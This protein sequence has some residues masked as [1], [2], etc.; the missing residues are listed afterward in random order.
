MTQTPKQCPC[1][2][3]KAY[4]HCCEPLHQGAPA[5]DAEQLMRS[6]YSAYALGFESYL[7]ETWH[8]STRPEGLDL[9]GKGAPRWCGLT[10]LRHEPNDDGTAVVEFIAKHEAG[11]LHEVSRFVRE[12]GRWLYVT[13]ETSR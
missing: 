10:V 5:Q 13:G 1:G 12:D 9:G 11:Q 4:A 3:G 8:R 7:L 6:R 2:S